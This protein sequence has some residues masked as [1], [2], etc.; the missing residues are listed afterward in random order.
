MD[1]TST[2]TKPA[3]KF[4]IFHER[5]VRKP[6]SI[7]KRS[8]P[9]ENSMIAASHPKQKPRIM[10]ETVRQS[11]NNTSRQADPKVTATDSPIP[12]HAANLIQTSRWYFG[13]CMQEPEN[14]A[15]GRAGASIHL[16]RAAA[17]ASPN[18]LIAEP[19][20]KLIGAVG[21][22]TI[23]HNDFRSRRSLAQMLEKR[24]YQRRLIQNRNNDRD[25]HLKRCC[26]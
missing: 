5:H 7:N 16:Y 17:F 26:R 12:D 3:K 18:E 13:V 11:V 22:C 10:C 23:D 25:L 21:A 24:T 6:S 19:R 15:A 4:N 1:H 8:S 20:R 14:I 2:A 9:T